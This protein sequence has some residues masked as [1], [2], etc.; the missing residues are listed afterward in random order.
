MD[1]VFEK[2]GLKP[3]TALSKTPY[4]LGKNQE[5]LKQDFIS[6]GFKNVR[7]WYQHN[8]FSFRDGQE[9]LESM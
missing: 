9:Y 5:S 1:V 8:N 2:H 3:K 6:L 7:I 4:D